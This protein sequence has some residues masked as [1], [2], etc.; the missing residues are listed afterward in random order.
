MEEKMILWQRVP[1]PG[2]EYARLAQVNSEWKL[3][4]T[5]LLLFESLPCRLDYQVIC[6]TAWHTRS[7]QVSGWVGD[8]RVETEMLVDEA[9]NWWLNGVEQAQVAGCIDLDLNFSPLTNTLP[10]RR[11]NLA[12]GQAAEVK[13]A[14]LRFPSF[15]LELLEQIY[16]RSAGDTYR[17]ESAGGSFTADLTVD[18]VGLVTNYPGQWI[19]SR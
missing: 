17:Y 19:R 10:I 3:T 18:E 15:R 5:A 7:A 11:L 8:Q 2:H 14:W 16:R 4:G 1:A 9:F 6:D 13:A 12:V